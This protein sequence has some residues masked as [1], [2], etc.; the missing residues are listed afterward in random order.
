[1]NRLLDRHVVVVVDDEPEVLSALKRS[2]R[3]EFCQVL[4]TESPEQALRWVET[5]DVSAIVADQRMP[6][7]TGTELLAWVGACRPGTA[8]II[9]TG[10]AARTSEIPHLK[11][12]IDCMIGKP[13]DDAMLRRTIRDF[14]SERELEEMSEKVAEHPKK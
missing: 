12:S 14:L 11:R 9:L 4:A 7:M 13:W 2:L 1:M 8:R 5:R 6:G 3:T 10:H